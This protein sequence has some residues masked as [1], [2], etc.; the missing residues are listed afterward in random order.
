MYNGG[1][2]SSDVNAYILK[3]AGWA[4]TVPQLLAMHGS[5]LGA[6]CPEHIDKLG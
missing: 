5:A 1:A 4:Y 3:G 2:T 6:F